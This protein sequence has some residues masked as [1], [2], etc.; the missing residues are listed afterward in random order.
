[1]MDRQILLPDGGETVAAIV[2]HAL[3]KAR[4][5]RLELEIGAIDRDDLR[6]L[7]ERQHTLV[8]EGLVRPDVELP[9]D[10]AAQGFRHL[11][12]E[13]EPD[14]RPAATTL[15]RGFIEE[16]QILGLFLDLEIAVADDAEHPLPLHLVAREEPRRVHGD[17]RLERDE[18][19]AAAPFEIRQADEALDLRRQAHERIEAPPVMGMDEL[20]GDAETEVRD[21]GERMRRVDGERRQ[22]REDVEQEMVFEP[23][24]F[25][26]VQARRLDDGDALVGKFAA[27]LAPAALLLGRQQRH[28]LADLGELFSRGQ[29]VL[30]G[31]RDARTRLPIEARNAHHEEFIEIVGGDRQEPQLLEQRMVAVPRFQQDAVV[32]TEPGQLAVDEAVRRLVQVGDVLGRWGIDRTRDGGQAC[33]RACFGGRFQA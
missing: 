19:R 23:G 12:I 5:I 9:G 28:A 31:R 3:G 29:T 25:R 1:M 20:E 10:E 26:A 27:K 2:A 18:A 32:E 6:Q 4:I 24:G 17:E 14:D 16:H 11:G 7:V 21:E 33:L 13:F 22:H 8:D 30:G 15:Q